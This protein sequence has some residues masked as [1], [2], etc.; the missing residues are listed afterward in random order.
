MFVVIMDVM[1]W[2][3]LNSAEVKVAAIIYF[4]HC[5]GLGTVRDLRTV[6]VFEST[7]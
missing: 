1:A 2:S 6:E 7:F 3:R 5:V 4:F